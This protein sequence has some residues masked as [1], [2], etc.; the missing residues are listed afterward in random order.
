VGVDPNSSG[1]RRRRLVL[2][3]TPLDDVAVVERRWS[4]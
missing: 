4:R 3:D 1:R 2:N